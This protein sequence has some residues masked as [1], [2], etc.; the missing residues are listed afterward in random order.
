MSCCNT[1][2]S[3]QLNI[4]AGGSSEEI[5]AFCDRVWTTLRVSVFV[6]ICPGLFTKKR[7]MSNC[8]DFLKSYSL[9]LKVFEATIVS[10]RSPVRLDC[11][12]LSLL[13]GVKFYFGLISTTDPVSSSPE[14]DMVL[15]GGLGEVPGF[16]AKASRA[17][18]KPRGSHRASMSP[19]CWM[20]SLSR[21]RGTDTPAVVVAPFPM[22]FIESSPWASPQSAAQEPS[23]VMTCSPSSKAPCRDWAPELFPLES[24]R[25]AFFAVS[26]QPMV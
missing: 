22:V 13:A 12:N 6:S 7:P 8:L 15:S 11:P 2:F 21:V 4:L 26:S 9:V 19:A 25:L 18:P 20:L 5:F 3:K 14:T 17:A 24:A 16:E 1:G 10:S 23:K